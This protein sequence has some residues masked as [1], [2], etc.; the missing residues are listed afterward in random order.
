MA[1]INFMFPGFLKDPETYDKLEDYWRTLIRTIVPDTKLKF[2][3]NVY[4]N[5]T[6]IRDGNPILNVIVNSVSIRV[7][8]YSETDY[9]PV[10][11]VE[12]DYMFCKYCN[13]NI[14]FV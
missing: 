13:P 14:E 11:P 12:P 7:L 2:I 4:A 3:D 5:G 6:K 1:N 9:N 8:V 10:V